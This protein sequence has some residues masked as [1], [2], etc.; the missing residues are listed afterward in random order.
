MATT[1]VSTKAN[2][3]KFGLKNVYYALLQS[4]SENG[5]TYGTPVKWPGA[6]SLTMDPSGDVEKFRADNMDYYVARGNNGYE[7][8]LEMARIIDSFRTDVLG[9]TVDANGVQVENANVEPK[10]FALLFEF[11][12]DAHQTRHAMYNISAGRPSV[13]SQTTDQSK[14]PV[15]ESSDMSASPLMNGVVK[16]STTADTDKTVYDNW[17]SS[18]YLPTA[19]GGEG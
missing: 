19:A 1:P 18:V 17:F 7:G 10:A 8:S 9:E 13:N 12:G 15:T 3:V 11:D 6:V 5:P 16:V 4:D 14:A 2:K